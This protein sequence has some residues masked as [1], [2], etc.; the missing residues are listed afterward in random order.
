VVLVVLDEVLT[1]ALPVTFP[2]DF[3]AT[4]AVSTA[5]VSAICVFT[6]VVLIAIVIVSR[7]FYTTAC[8]QCDACSL[9]LRP[10]VV[11]FGY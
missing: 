8:I 4:A 1:A 2:V 3:F 5:A 9:M 6:A 10:C 7:L 11:S